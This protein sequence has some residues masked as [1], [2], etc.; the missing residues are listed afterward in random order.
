[1]LFLLTR[2]INV[3][4]IYLL[5]P[6]LLVFRKEVHLSRMNFV[7]WIYLR[8]YFVISFQRLI[9]LLLANVTKPLLEGKKVCN[10]NERNVQKHVVH[11][12]S[13]HGPFQNSYL[14][15]DMLS[16]TFLMIHLLLLL[17]LHNTRR[18]GF[19]CLPI[20]GIVGPFL[21]ILR[22]AAQK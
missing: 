3:L 20:L 12:I 15:H 19:S 5:A 21:I 17:L 14:F 18:Q 16:S 13:V 8:K 1:M 4:S 2:I 9:Q 6:L 22:Q 7:V 10:V 11:C